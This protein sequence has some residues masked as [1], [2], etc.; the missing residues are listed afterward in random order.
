MKYKCPKCQEQIEINVGKLLAK[1]RNPEV[2]RKN[3]I[4]GKEFGK[5]GGRPVNPDSARQKRLALKTN[6]K[7]A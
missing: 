6:P 5:L 4:K 2:S 3:G 7:Q 1:G